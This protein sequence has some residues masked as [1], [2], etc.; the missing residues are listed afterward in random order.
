MLGIEGA[1]LTCSYHINSFFNDYGVPPPCTD[2][3]PT[4]NDWLIQVARRGGLA[5]LNHPGGSA[6]NDGLAWVLALFDDPDNDH[7]VGMELS[8]G[9]ANDLH[10]ALWDQLL[11][12]L[13]PDRP[14]WG[15]GSSDMHVLSQTQ[16]AFTVF[17]LDELTEAS[18][19]EAMRSGQFYTVTGPGVVDLSRARTQPP[20]AAYEG[21]YPELRSVVVNREAAE[22]SI[23][24]RGYDEIVWISK[25]SSSEPNSDS[26]AATPWPAARVV[27][28][29]PVFDYSDLRSPYVRAEIINHT[30]EG[31]I[32]VFLNPF[33]LTR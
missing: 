20:A 26:E 32:R 33:A 1:E 30:D 22:I 23:D 10:V 17:L 9:G 3:R 31:P 5:V 14:I 18:V 19:K 15:F 16:F 13:M 6:K 11:A 27:Q 21:T 12:D 8:G 24:A 2:H 28:R 25:P 4:P 29:G 7:L